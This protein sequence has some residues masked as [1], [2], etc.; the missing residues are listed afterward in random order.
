VAAFFTAPSIAWGPGAVEQLSGLAARRALVVVDPAVA[1]GDGPRRVTEEL[2][3]A[4]TQVEVTPAGEAPG[5]TASVARLRDAIAAAGPD[6][7]VA[8][9]GG[10]TIDG[11]KA[12]RWAAEVPGVSIDA[13]PSIVE[14]PNPP[15]SRLVAIPTTSGSGSE[16]SWAADLSGE[17]G[18]PI[19]IAHRALVPEWALVDP[20]FARGRPRAQVLA[21]ALEIAGLAAEAYLSAWANPFSDALAVGALGTVLARLPHAVRW[22][23]DPEAPDALH[24]AATTAGLAASNAQR[25][26]AHALAR[27]LGPPTGLSYATL[28]GI[29]LPHVLDFDRPACRERLDVL[30]DAV[31]RPDETARPS[32]ADRLRR[33]SEGLGLPPT[34]VAAGVER[35]SVDG[36]RRSVVERTLRSPAALANPRVP[37]AADLEKLLDA[38]LGGPG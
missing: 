1:R 35:G 24:Y 18:I 26:L 23:D 20:A 33:L 25:G 17:G 9:G 5:S 30:A 37:G 3:K 12:A 14:V 21:E 28:L 8:L 38:V 27:A 15:R 13:P 6:W 10:S 19:E 2:E 32:V 11:A 4:G 16:A 34:V 22:S 36:A 29:A 31:A 7:I